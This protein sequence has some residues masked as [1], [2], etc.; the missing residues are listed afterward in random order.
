MVNNNIF[1]Q[2]S[3]SKATFH[4][5]KNLVIKTNQM[6]YLSQINYYWFNHFVYTNTIIS[7]PINPIS[8]STKKYYVLGS[9][10]HIVISVVGPVT[11]TTN[12]YN[13]ICRVL[14]FNLITNYYSDYLVESLYKIIIRLF[15]SWTLIQELEFKN[16][17]LT[18]EYSKRI[19]N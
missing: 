1:F 16:K 2:L 9:I 15:Q 5:A 6:T 19:K 11:M 7:R 4:S 17:T 14:F 8:N 18:Y 3:R 13:K 10:T 12:N